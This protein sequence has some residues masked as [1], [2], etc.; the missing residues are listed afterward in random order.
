M[1]VFLENSI[2]IKNLR[3][4]EKP[5]LRAYYDIARKMMCQFVQ[6]NQKNT[7]KNIKKVN[8]IKHKKMIK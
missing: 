7:I 5:I 2:N 1:A 3:K 4:M 8:R 6:I